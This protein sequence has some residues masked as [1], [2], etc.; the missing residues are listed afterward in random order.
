MGHE[1]ANLHLATP[2]Q[3]TTLLHDLTERKQDWL[4][5]AANAMSKATEQDWEQFR[6]SQLAGRS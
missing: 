4:V 1:T 3:R 6:S 2:D 5:N